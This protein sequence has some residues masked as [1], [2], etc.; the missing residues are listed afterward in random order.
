MLVNTCFYHIDRKIHFLLQGGHKK[1]TAARKPSGTSQG[2]CLAPEDMRSTRGSLQCRLLPP[3]Q[4]L[5][6]EHV[7]FTREASS[8]WWCLGCGKVSQ[9]C[10]HL[11]TQTGSDSWSRSRSPVSF[12]PLSN[13]GQNLHVY[14]VVDTC[15]G[16]DLEV[17]YERRI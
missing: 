2:R 13:Q 10:I 11:S 15:L 3:T 16:V 1:L 9:L 5:H 7:I 14:S 8:I 12:N 6:L 4:P 17:Q